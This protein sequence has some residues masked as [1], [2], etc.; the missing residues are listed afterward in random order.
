MEVGPASVVT[1][2][3]G[4]HVVVDLANVG[5]ARLRP[6]TT[7][8]VLDEAGV[9]VIDQQFALGSILAFSETVL[10]TTFTANS[11]LCNYRV[12]L[13]LEQS[14][15]GYTS[16]RL[17]FDIVVDEAALTFRDATLSRPTIGSLTVEP[18]VANGRVAYADVVV[19]VDNPGQDIREATVVLSIFCNGVKVED[20]PITVGAPLLAGPSTVAARYIPPTGWQPG[21]YT[22]SITLASIDPVSGRLVELAVL[23]SPDTVVI[24]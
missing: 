6:V 16:G 24:P 22:F 14:E 11:A 5:N 13:S 21:T 7:I 8:R 15:K 2:A 12:E 1:T 10:T 17:T 20:Y 9:A 4:T 18:V 3:R 19:A 23:E